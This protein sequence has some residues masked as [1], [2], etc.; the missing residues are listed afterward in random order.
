MET[1]FADY[2][3]AFYLAGSL[4]SRGQQS[5]QARET[6]QNIFCA[7]DEEL[8][9]EAFN[10]PREVVR[11][12]QQEDEER[13]IIVNVRQGMRV[14]RPSKEEEGQEQRHGPKILR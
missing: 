7:F 10:V 14:I 6:F 8:M 3:G 1:K 12:M 5:Q 11:K 4:P 2:T 9:S 13:R